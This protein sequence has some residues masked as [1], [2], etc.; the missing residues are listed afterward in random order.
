MPMLYS[1]L[2]YMLNNSYVGHGE[3]LKLYSWFFRVR[4]STIQDMIVEV[5]DLLTTKW[6]KIPHEFERDWNYPNLL[7]TMDG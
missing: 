4:K 1:I 3:R 6:L 7:G 5:S 2:I